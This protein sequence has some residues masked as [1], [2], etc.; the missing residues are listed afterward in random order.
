VLLASIVFPGTL[1]AS[2]LDGF[3][4]AGIRN[5]EVSR[6]H[7]PLAARGFSSPWPRKRRLRFIVSAKNGKPT[8]PR[9]PPG[10]DPAAAFAAQSG[11][12]LAILGSRRLAWQGI[13]GGKGCR[14]LARAS[15]VAAARLAA[16]LAVRF[17][18]GPEGAT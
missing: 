9:V 14:G 8:G 10:I 16:R 5:P 18:P 1:P 12:G 7:G 6:K 17:L 3:V 11:S 2:N 13:E 4:V 15:S